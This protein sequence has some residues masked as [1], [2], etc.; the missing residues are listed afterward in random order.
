[1][2]YSGDGLPDL[3]AVKQVDHRFAAGVLLEKCRE[4][5]IAAVALDS[6]TVVEDRL[7][8]IDSG[9]V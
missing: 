2:V 5:G 7:R 4:A 6:F 3:E 9:Q 1:M 8:A